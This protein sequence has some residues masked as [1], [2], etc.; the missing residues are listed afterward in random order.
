MTVLTRFF[1]LSVLVLSPVAVAI[2]L[3]CLLVAR[4]SRAL[5]VIST[6]GTAMR[7]NLPL[8]MALETAAGQNTDKRAKTLRGISKWLVQGHSLSYAIAQGYSG[9]PAQAVAMITAAE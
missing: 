9:C 5:Y 3:R 7:Q 4:N 6:I 2:I 1:L 8:A